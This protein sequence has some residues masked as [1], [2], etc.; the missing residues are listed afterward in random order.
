[1]LYNIL[2]VIPY[3]APAWG[4]G[5]PVRISWDLAKKSSSVGHKVTVFTTTISDGKTKEFASGEEFINNIRVVRFPNDNNWAASQKIWNP[6]GLSEQL[7][8]EIKQFDLICLHEYRTLLNVQVSK[9]ALQNKTP[10][11]LFAYGTIPRGDGWKV[12]AKFLFDKCWGYK[13]IK[14]ANRVFAQTTNEKSEYRKSGVS[15]QKI[16]MF[17]LM[18]NLDEFKILP[19]KKYAREKFNFSQKDFVILFLGRLHKYK[20]IELIIRAVEG[21]KNKIPNLKLLIVGNDEGY[22]PIIKQVIKKKNLGAFIKISPPLYEKERLFAYCASDLFVLTPYFYE[23]TSL[24]ALEALACGIPVIVTKQAEIPHLVQYHAGYIIKHDEDI[25]IENINYFYENKKHMHFWSL[26]A[27]KLI[28]QK[29]N[30]GHLYY[31]FEQYI[32]SIL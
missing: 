13:M 15:P 25:L 16:S 18:V 7:N 21:L 8:K 22:L 26:N 28:K 23:E 4:F 12:L 27:K 32:Q 31:Q 30:L 5:G 29:Y 1:M 24:A 3:F 20:G 14:N 19:T 6:K 9:L 17:P 10:Y 11:F 2:H